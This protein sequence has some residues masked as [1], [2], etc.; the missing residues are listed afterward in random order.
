MNGQKTWVQEGDQIAYSVF[1]SRGISPV[2]MPLTDVLT[3]LQTELLDSAAV[4]AVGAVV[5]QLHSKLSYI[6]DLPLSYVYGA[7]VIDAKPFSML[8]EPDQTVVCGVMERIYKKI[9]E[10]SILDNRQALAALVEKGLKMVEPVT[11]EVPRWYKLVAESNLQLAKKGL[12]PESRMQE[13]LSHLDEFRSGSS[14]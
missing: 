4:S 8:S 10:A 6:T 14:Q 1:K 11:E 5:L 12:I 7:L 3:G 2:T 13:M 9:D